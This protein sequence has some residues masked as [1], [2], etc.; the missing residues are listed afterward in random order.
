VDPAAKSILVLMPQAPKDAAREA[1]MRAR[2][3]QER[4]DDAIFRAK[5]EEKQSRDRIAKSRRTMRVSVK[6]G[7]G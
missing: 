7:L 5:Q 1:G 6:R 4:A 2:Q 3:R